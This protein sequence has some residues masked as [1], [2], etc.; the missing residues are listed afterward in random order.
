VKTD[1]EAPYRH[2]INVLDELQG[3]GAERISLQILE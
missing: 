3:A 2:M 1:P